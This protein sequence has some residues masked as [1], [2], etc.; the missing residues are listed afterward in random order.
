MAAGPDHRPPGMPSFCFVMECYF[1]FVAGGGGGGWF[2]NFFPGGF[3]GFGGGPGH[4]TNRGGGQPPPAGFR[5]DFTNPG[6]DNAGERSFTDDETRH[7]VI[8][9]SR[10]SHQSTSKCWS[11]WFRELFHRRSIGCSRR[12]RFWWSQS[13]VSENIPLDS[14]CLHET[15]FRA[16]NQYMPNAGNTGWFGGGG[17]ATNTY[18]PDPSPSSGG[19]HTSSGKSVSSSVSQHCRDTF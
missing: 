5:T 7:D 6:F 15:G 19:T 17:G 16:N 10:L 4:G 13:T 2:S 14:L 12:L 3:G 11:G 8:S 1:A 9:I 18:R